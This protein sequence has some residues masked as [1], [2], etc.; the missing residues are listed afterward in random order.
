MAKKSF[1]FYF[2]DC[3]SIKF[4]LTFIQFCPAN[5]QSI[6]W[7]C[8]YY[9]HL[10]PLMDWLALFVMRHALHIKN[11]QFVCNSSVVIVFNF[12]PIKMKM[13]EK[14]KWK[15]LFHLCKFQLLS[16]QMR[17]SSNIN[18]N[19]NNINKQK[20]SPLNCFSFISLFFRVRECVLPNIILLGT[21]CFNKLSEKNTPRIY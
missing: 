7:Y 16:L 12:T 15:I 2:S 21:M 18:N 3:Y 1:L 8:K 13:K 19:S 4:L 10:F 14:I 9:F 11:K 17:T 5:V 20:K 6:A